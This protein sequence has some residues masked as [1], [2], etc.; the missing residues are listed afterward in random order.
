MSILRI[1]TLLRRDILGGFRS[2][3]LLFAI[4]IPLLIT[5]LIQ[6]VLNPLFEPV[7]RIGVVDLGDSKITQEIKEV[8]GIEVFLLDETDLLKEKI[9]LNDLDAGFILEKDFDQLLLD[10]KN[11]EFDFYISG[12]SGVYERI[13][14]TSVVMDLIRQVEDKDAVVNVEEILLG[15]EYLPMSE[16]L[17]PLIAFF[18]LFVG[19]IFVPAMSLVQER[20]SGTLNAVLVSPVRI[21][22]VICSK[23]ILGFVLGIVM[24]LATLVLNNAIGNEPFAL[25]IAI[26]ISML[27]LSE[28]GII[29]ALLSK[30]VQSFYTIMKGSQIILF[31][32]AVLY[33]WPDLPD[34]ILKIFPTYWMIEPIYQVGVKGGDFFDISFELFISILICIVLLPIILLLARRMEKSLF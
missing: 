21:S 14:S 18:S 2:N 1:L 31:T 27:M 11:P 13:L 33:I 30:D 12:D 26:L 10:D 28:I 3:L 15:E 17:V 8:E 5:F 4:I 29:F 25:L 23:V 34:W 16:R 19:G 32:P 24:T 20:E 6:V 7:P 9:E 22:E